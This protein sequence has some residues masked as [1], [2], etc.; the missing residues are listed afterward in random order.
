MRQRSKEFKQW[1]E[2]GTEI[3]AADLTDEGKLRL[4]IKHELMEDR[5]A[6]NHSVLMLTAV[7]FLVYWGLKKGVTYLISSRIQEYQKTQARN[8]RRMEQAKEKQQKRASKGLPTKK[9][10]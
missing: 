6:P 8:R 9:R 3:D 2:I 5:V 1:Q 4:K 10:R 7:P